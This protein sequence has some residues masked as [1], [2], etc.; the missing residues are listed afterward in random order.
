VDLRIF[1]G[2]IDLGKKG[3]YLKMSVKIAKYINMYS[4]FFTYYEQ[5]MEK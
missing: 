4:N 5:D 1:K 3:N 2:Y